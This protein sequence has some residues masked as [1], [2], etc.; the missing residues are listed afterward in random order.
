MR[1]RSIRPLPGQFY[2]GLALLATVRKDLQ[3]EALVAF[4]NDFHFDE[5]FQHGEKTPLNA[6]SF[7]GRSGEQ[8]CT[9]TSGTGHSCNMKRLNDMGGR[10]S[11][12]WT[13]YDVEKLRALAGRRTTAQIAKELDRTIGAI[14]QKAFDL[15]LSLR[16]KSQPE[17]IA[18]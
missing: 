6:E 9:E 5:L 4:L 8:P 17:E 14:I 15:R 7:C 12:A 2:D 3:D 1:A 18:P 13:G 11:R 10:V 16:A